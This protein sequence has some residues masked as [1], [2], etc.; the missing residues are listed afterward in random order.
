MDK[1]FSE[2]A[3]DTCSMCLGDTECRFCYGALAGARFTGMLQLSTTRKGD[4]VPAKSSGP[5]MVCH[6]I[7]V[8]GIFIEKRES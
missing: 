5:Q 7:G 6:I 1:K 2:H 8:Q 3:Q 4:V